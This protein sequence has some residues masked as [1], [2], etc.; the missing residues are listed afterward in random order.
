M[1]LCLCSQVMDI[2]LRLFDVGTILS[3][4]PGNVQREK[5]KNNEVLLS[6]PLVSET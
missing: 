2:F 3:M 4:F 6:Q 5:Q 1:C